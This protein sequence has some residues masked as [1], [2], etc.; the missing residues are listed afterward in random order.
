[1]KQTLLTI[2]TSLALATIS[3]AQ[4][5]T[6]TSVNNWQIGDKQVILT[7][8]S[9]GV[10]PG[11]SGANVTWDYSNLKQDSAMDSTITVFRDA[12]TT[13]YYS[14]FPT[15]NI[16]EYDSLNSGY[17]YY[18]VNSSEIEMLG[19]V[20][21]DS[22]KQTATKVPFSNSLVI[23]TYPVTYGYTHGDTYAA[24]TTAMGFKV[25]V[26]GAIQ[27]KADGYGTLKIRNKTYNDVIRLRIINI[28]KDSLNL[29]PFGNFVVHDTSVSFNY[30]TPGKKSAILT[31][32]YDVNK[33]DTNPSIRSKT[34]TFNDFDK[35]HTSGIAANF[36]DNISCELFPNPASGITNLYIM[37]QTSS[38]ARITITNQ[39]GQ[40]VNEMNNYHLSTGRNAI[41]L[42][43]KNYT[44]GIYFINIVNDGSMV[45]Q[46]LVIN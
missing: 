45:T 5:P 36:Q 12:K 21:Y 28:S 34:V 27:E 1:M 39:F 20:N 3:Y 30:Y 16:V 8:D 33:Q 32:T 44:K 9:T 38:Q 37:T 10:E 6:I 2:A 23:V 15:S 26:A 19:I 4:S 43:L 17:T 35:V 41:S 13:P 31:I 18:N 22:T 29:G 25:Y 24:S 7:A 14:D 40:V 42:D 46:K 11:A